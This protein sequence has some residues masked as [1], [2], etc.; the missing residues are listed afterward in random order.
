M[1]QRVMSI[2]PFVIILYLKFTA[3][4]FIQPLYGNAAGAAIM[5]VCLIIYTV[6]YYLSKRIVN[7]E[8]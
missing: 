1:E 8:I 4:D 3:A 2:I 5:T 6:S 7:I